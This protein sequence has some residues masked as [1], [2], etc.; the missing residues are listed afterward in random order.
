MSVNTRSSRLEHKHS[1]VVAV[2]AA[3]AVF[4]APAAANHAVVPAPPLPP[5][6]AVQVPGL[7]AQG[8]G[9]MKVL[10]LS[11]YDGWFWAD[12]H[13]WHPDRTYLLD[14]HYHRDLDGARL[15][16]RSVVEIEGIGGGT[17][18]DRL[19]WGEA[20]RRILPDVGKGDRITGIHLPPGIVRYFLNGAFIGEIADP[21]FA[22]AF[23]GIWLDPK[24]S[25]TDF[26]RKLLGERP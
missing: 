19:R 5:L 9:E 2:A 23:F 14:L 12:G 21:Q 24:T 26:R 16:E 6:V 8:G 4:A 7:R 18:E 25:R 10:G 22:R 1:A 15:A 13:A 11:I 20:M 3:V 17:P